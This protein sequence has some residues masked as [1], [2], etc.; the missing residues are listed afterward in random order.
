MINFNMGKSKLSMV[1]VDDIGKAVLNI[2]SNYK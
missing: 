2:F 1:D